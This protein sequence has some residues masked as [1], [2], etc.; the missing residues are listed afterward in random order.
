MCGRFTQGLEL[1]VLEKRFAARAEE[2]LAV[3]QRYNLAP[4]QEASVIIH[5]KERKIVLMR[6]GLIPSWAKDV[7]IGNKLINARAETAREKPSFRKA[8]RQ[9][10]CLVPADG[11]YEWRA[12][13][14]GKPKIPLYFRRGD[15]APFAMAG[16]WESWREPGGH[17]LRSFT[18]LTTT[19]NT[20][21]ESVHDRMPVMLL[22]ENEALWL[23]PDQH[24]P[25]VL[26]GLLGP[27]PPEL[28]EAY[29]VSAAVNSPTHEG[30]T[31]IN[32]VATQEGVLLD[33]S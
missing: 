11:F 18:I 25:L 32:P 33:K 31:L 19:A 27:Y 3:K 15:R 23:N 22:P 10:R 21:V 9:S 12:A 28:M 29:E 14:K 5:E 20:V 2:G 4:T 13:G 6:W 8:F 16:L 26:A 24:D 7:G 1:A 17:N 30:P